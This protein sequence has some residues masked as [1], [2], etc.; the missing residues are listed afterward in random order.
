MTK[1]E[2]LAKV[3]SSIDEQQGKLEAL[4]QQALEGSHEALADIQA[5]IGDLEPKLEQAKLKAEEI[6][7]IADDAWDYVKEAL[8]AGWHEFAAKLEEGWNS[9]TS[10]VKS[11]FS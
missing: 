1:E 5:A 10:T 4:K 7:N 2:L 8:E 6:A 11:F 9:F 3:Q